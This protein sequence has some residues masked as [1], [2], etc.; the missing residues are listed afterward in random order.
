MTS[1]PIPVILDTDIGDDIDDTW[2][3]V[4]L[5]RCPELDV[6]LVTSTSWNPI[7]RARHIAKVLDLAG[8]SDIPVGIGA[9]IPEE[10]HDPKGTI[11][12]PW[13]QDYPLDAYPGTVY[14]DG[15]QAVIDTIHQSSQPVT[16]I[17]IGPLS[18]LGEALKRDPSITRNSRFVGMFGSV[19]K[20]YMDAPEACSET[21]VRLF[22]ESCRNV[23]R[24]DW[25][26]TITPLDTCGLVVLDGEDYA[27]IRRSSDPLIQE[28]MKANDIFAKHVPWMKYDPAERSSVLFDAVAIYLAYC[29]ELLTME[30]LPLRIDDGGFTRID[31]EVGSPTRCALGWEDLEAF[32]KHLVSRLLNGD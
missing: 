22:T 29:E 30:T 8:R 18:N 11:I 14:Q 26:K 32:K 24:S 20:G 12:F 25:N 6:K 13:I 28:L 15:P 5:L 23:F 3:L 27:A 21:N 7:N 17:A 10:T 9:R 4:M 1:K 16:V 19:Y 31:A 2:A